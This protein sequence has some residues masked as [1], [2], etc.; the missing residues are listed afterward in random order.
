MDIHAVV[1]KAI[2]SALLANTDVTNLVGTR[3]FQLAA[4]AN[5][6]LPYITFWW[7][8]GGFI[9]DNPKR[10]FDTVFNIVGV[11][12]YAGQAQTISTA[13]YETLVGTIPTFD[14]DWKAWAAVTV[15]DGFHDMSSVQNEQ[16][17]RFG[18]QYRFRGSE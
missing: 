6:P 12:A 9:N 11:S 3:I 4:P 17:W 15:L 5:T 14:G 13:I 18:A 1:G 7:T 2:R 8:G 10:A 16:Y